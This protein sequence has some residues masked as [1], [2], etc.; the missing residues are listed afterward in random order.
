MASSETRIPPIE[1]LLPPATPSER[2]KRGLYEAG[3]QIA[4]IGIMALAARASIT[5]PGLA[6]PITL[7][8]LVVVSLGALYGWKRGSVLTIGY[9]ASGFVVGL[10]VFAPSPRR[11]FWNSQSAGFLLG[12][13]VAAAI[14]GT[15]AERRSISGEKDNGDTRLKVASRM[16]GSMVLGHSAVLATGFLWL[17][18]FTDWRTAF[19]SGVL[20]FLPGG[21]VKSG[22]GA[23][24]FTAVDSLV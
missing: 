7:Q 4:G 1:R 20:P 6:A 23:V 18:R 8:S 12:F 10:P 13:P 21:L 24:L 5:I 15:E 16:F 2:V 22:F 11:G 3:L 9:L 14:A 19:V 17:L